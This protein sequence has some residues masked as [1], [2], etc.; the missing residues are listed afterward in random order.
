[1]ELG[2]RPGRRPVTLAGAVQRDGRES[3]GDRLLTFDLPICLPPDGDY[4]C[5]VEGAPA[6]LRIDAAR[7]YLRGGGPAASRVTVELTSR[8][9]TAA[10]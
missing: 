1:M 10:R 8:D 6:T 3:G 4:G 9:A 5:A 2:R 7:A